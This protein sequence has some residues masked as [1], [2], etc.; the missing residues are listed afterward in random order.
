M[1]PAVWPSDTTC[2]GDSDASVG[3]VIDVLPPEKGARIMGQTIDGEA[4][5][6][7]FPSLLEAGPGD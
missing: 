1:G 6:V 7:T 2:P 3:V 4:I 5:Q